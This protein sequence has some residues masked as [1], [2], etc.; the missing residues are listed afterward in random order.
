MP[1]GVVDTR[2]DRPWSELDKVKRHLDLWYR[3]KEESTRK[4]WPIS[5]NEGLQ[6]LRAA[7]DRYVDLRKRGRQSGAPFSPK[8]FYSMV[9]MMFIPVIAMWHL[10]WWEMDPYLRGCAT[11]D[12]PYESR[13]KVLVKV[14]EDQYVDIR[15]LK[16]VRRITFNYVMLRSIFSEY[17]NINW[18]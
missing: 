16:V 12:V 14:I 9:G 7:M 18:V 5:P 15:L 13:P 11:G 8:L 2:F 1:I 10:A 6:V 3:L 4:R 17:I